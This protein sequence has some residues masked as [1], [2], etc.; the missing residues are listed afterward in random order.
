MSHSMV[1]VY[2]PSDS[3]V[4]P[5]HKGYFKQPVIA[6]CGHTFCRAC[7]I[8][9][10]CKCPIDNTATRADDLIPNLAVS[11]QINDMLVYCKYGI[12]TTAEGD[13]VVDDDG[14]K[15][16][17]KL[18]DKDAHEET[19]DYAT[20]S[21]PYCQIPPMRRSML[22]QHLDVCKEIPCPHQGAGCTYHGTRESVDG[23]LK[24]CGYESIKAYISKSEGQWNSVRGL[25]EDKLSE[26]DYLKK[27]LLQLTDRL[28]QF[29]LKTE[30]KLN[31]QETALRHLQTSLEATQGQLSD[32][33]NLWKNNNDRFGNDA[34]EVLVDQNGQQLLKCKG[35]ITGHNGPVWALTI[36]N[37]HTL[38]SGSSDTTIKVWDLITYKCKHTLVGHQGIV[39]ALSSIGN[40]LFS[41][42]S[43]KFI[44]VW[45]LETNECIK[46]LEGHDDAVCTLVVAGGFLFSGSYTHLKVW[47]LET[48]NCVETLKGH[49]HWVR[50]ITVNGGYLYSGSYNLVKVW[51]LGTFQCVKTIAGNCGSIYSIAVNNRRLIA[52]SYENAII[53]WDLDS[54]ELIT[55]LSGHIG[56]VY[57]VSGSPGNRFYSG[58]YDS[59][60]KVWNSD[61]LQCIQTLNRHTSSVECLVAHNNS[62]FSGSADNTIKVWRC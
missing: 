2:P 1:F 51:D 21:C 7:I 13:L 54:Y 42:S 3:L 44:R 45:D 16:K 4:C 47:D 48:Y 52:G 56:A 61:T 29:I 62:I 24:I 36:A 40:R 25:L 35:T 27:S 55:R 5:I 31:K 28:D 46:V 15:K 58:S 23:H 30:S 8:H 49:N 50:A 22:K 53:V 18:L 39:H 26:N 59:T 19:C 38:L 9:Y 37:G 12:K 6:K 60:I 57:S 20:S 41:G 33:A 43:D 32:F 11:G 14:C 34:A 10:H 17:V